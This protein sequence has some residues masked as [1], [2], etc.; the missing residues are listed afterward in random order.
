[1]RK[2]CM[3]LQQAINM[4]HS[5]ASSTASPT[6]DS[7]LSQSFH[8][9]ERP[10]AC[11]CGQAQCAYLEHNNAALEGLEKGLHSAAQIGQV[12]AR[13]FATGNPE[14]YLCWVLLFIWDTSWD[15]SW[16]LVTD[17]CAIGIA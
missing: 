4:A 9:M 16:D 3:R 12:S 10:T 6:L 2:G 7:L 5:S 8:T 14:S 1:M 13:L 17:V 11:C 15:P